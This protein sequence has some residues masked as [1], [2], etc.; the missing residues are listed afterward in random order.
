MV[1]KPDNDFR[2]GRQLQLL[3][4]KVRTVDRAGK[5]MTLDLSEVIF[6]DSSLFRFVLNT[7]PRYDKVIPPTSEH[8]ITRYNDWL[9]SK[10]G[11]CKC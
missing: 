4:K 1:I 2:S 6:M 9:D 10:K 5:K 8:V 3:Y 7:L 11:L